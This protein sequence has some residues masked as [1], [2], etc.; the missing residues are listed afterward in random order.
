M[1][2]ASVNKKLHNDKLSANINSNNTIKLCPRREHTYVWLLFRCCD[3][4]INPMTYKLEGDLNTLEMYLHTEN[5]VAMLRHSKLLI[6]DDMFTANE[7]NTK[8]AES[9]MSPTF[10]NF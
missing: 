9:Q 5:E 6:E 10:N 8:T 7:K 3:L 2:T 1:Q 4:D